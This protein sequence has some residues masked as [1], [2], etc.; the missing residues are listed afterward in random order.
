[1]RTRGVYYALYLR[2]EGLKGADSGIDVG[3]EVGVAVRQN[4]NRLGILPRAI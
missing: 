3:L 2:D 1:M 4:L